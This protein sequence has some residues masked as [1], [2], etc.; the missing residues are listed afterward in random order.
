MMF[1]DFWFWCE[2]AWIFINLNRCVKVLASKNVLFYHFAEISFKSLQCI[3]YLMI[4][5]LNSSK[6]YISSYKPCS[7][8]FKV[9]FVYPY[10]IQKLR[11]LMYILFCSMNDIVLLCAFYGDNY[12]SFLCLFNA[13][14]YSTVSLAQYE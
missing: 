7:I 1:W 6:V 11:I 4:H 5:L 9:S 2:K 10:I 14:Q 8:P 13:V 12:F 3:I